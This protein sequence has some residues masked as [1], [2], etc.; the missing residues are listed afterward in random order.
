MLCPNCNC[1]VEIE[2]GLNGSTTFY[3]PKVIRLAEIV[4]K[5]NIPFRCKVC[6]NLKFKYQA[7]NSIVFI[8]PDPIE[9]KES[10]IV[11]PDYIKDFINSDIGT[12]LSVGPGYYDKKKKRFVQTEIKP[13][14][15][16]IFDKN[17]PWKMKVSDDFGN[18]H[19]VIYMAEADVKGIIENE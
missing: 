1:E 10:R 16:V 19:T 4:V 5:Y 9:K 12:V 15:R 7:V 18:E 11:I 2:P 13:G 8:Y 14:D 6:G 17:V 3:K